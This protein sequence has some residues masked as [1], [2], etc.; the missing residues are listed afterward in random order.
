MATEPPIF[1]L[2]PIVVSGV[3]LRY[4]PVVGSLVR[5]EMP[6]IWMFVTARPKVWVVVSTTPGVIAVRAERS[7]AFRVSS[8]LRVECRDADGDLR[9]VHARGLPWWR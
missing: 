8:A 7:F 3:S 1:V 5:E 2:L 9:H 6:R 4:M